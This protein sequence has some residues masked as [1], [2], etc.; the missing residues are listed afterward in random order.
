M[1]NTI[2]SSVAIPAEH[3][4]NIFGDFD[5]HL[6]SIENTL[7]VEMIERDGVLKMIGEESAVKKAK[8]LLGQ[9]LL[10]SERGRPLGNPAKV[11]LP[12]TT[13]WPVVRRLKFFISSGI[14]ISSPSLYP[15]AQ[16]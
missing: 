4:R 15:I 16:F 14:C 6:K 2:E 7:H 3:E 1:G 12:S 13:V 9:L 11:F 8:R 5:Q 10:L